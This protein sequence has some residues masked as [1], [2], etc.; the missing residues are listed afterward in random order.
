MGQL[1]VPEERTELLG[2]GHSTLSLP[3]LSFSAVWPRPLCPFGAGQASCCFWGDTAHLL[4]S[5]CAW[6][7]PF[8]QAV[9][10]RCPWSVHRAVPDHA[11]LVPHGL[12]QRGAHQ[13]AAASLGLVFLRRF[14][15]ALPDHAGH[16]A[17]E[18]AAAAPSPPTHEIRCPVCRMAASW[19]PPLGD[20]VWFRLQH[21]VACELA[22]PE[23]PWAGW[24]LLML[25]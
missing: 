18:G 3:S 13:A 19:H 4:P 1:A 12:R 14:P 24:E 6:G 2:W 20:A 10:C 15:G 16:A 21:H 11:A 23:N 7:C 8:L 9:P 25:S 5:S 17:P 22:P